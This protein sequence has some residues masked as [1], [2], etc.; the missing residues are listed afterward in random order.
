MGGIGGIG[1]MGGM[2]AKFGSGGTAGMPFEVLGLIVCA[3]AGMGTLTS[4]VRLFC[5]AVARALSILRSIS[6]RRASLI[7]SRVRAMGDRGET[8]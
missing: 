4:T 6:A 5:S 3:G 1:G 8:S 7:W 2:F